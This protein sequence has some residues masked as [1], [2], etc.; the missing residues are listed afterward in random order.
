MSPANF[1][2]KRTDI[3][4]ICS[5]FVTMHS[6]DETIRNNLAALPE[7]LLRP[8]NSKK[9]PM[10]LVIGGQEEELPLP[11][12]V[13]NF[14]AV[15]SD[16]KL[17]YIDR[18]RN[19]A[20]QYAIQDVFFKEEALVKKVLVRLGID[21][22]NNVWKIFAKKDNFEGKPSI[23][24]ILLSEVAPFLEHVK[25]T[26]FPAIDRGIGSGQY[27]YK[28]TGEKCHP[29]FNDFWEDA[30]IYK[31]DTETFRFRPIHK[32]GSTYEFYINT[33]GSS[34]EYAKYFG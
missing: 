16:E 23:V 15:A 32:S 31:S 22:W 17:A 1:D 27:P 34:P 28:S 4:I 13:F 24:S 25:E 7:Q 5:Q 21:A 33:P 9:R 2:I 20:Y 10:D 8:V 6:R 19:I 12:R 3:F 30:C 26:V 11:K 14:R 29:C 18:C